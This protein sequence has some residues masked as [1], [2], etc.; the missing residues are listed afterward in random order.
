MSVPPLPI[1]PIDGAEFGALVRTVETAFGE[2]A[3]P[4]DIERERLVFE[5]DRSLAAFDGDRMVG[6]TWVF[7]FGLSVPGG[8]LPAAGVTGVGVLP[9][10]RR[11]G[12]LTR[13]MRRQVD[14]VRD[15]GEPLAALWASEA[16]IY[17]RFGYAPAT[18]GAAHR[19]RKRGATALTRAPAAGGLVRLVDPDFALAAF[20]P[21]YERARSARTG[22]P[23]RRGRW[24]EYQLLADPERHRSGHSDK[25]LITYTEADEVDGYAVYRVKPS[26]DDRGAPTGTVDVVEL[27]AAT[28][29][30]GAALWRHCLG[31]DLTTNI[32][33]PRR[34]LDDP[35]PL[36]LD[37]PRQAQVVV[38][39]ALWLRLV[40]V[41]AALSGRSYASTGRLTLD[42]RDAFCPWNDGRWTLETD[43]SEA[44]C[45]RTRGSADLVLDQTDLA[46][47]YLGGTTATGLAL[48]ARIEERT[49]GA[50]ARLD[51]L[52]R[53]P[54]A[55]WAPEVF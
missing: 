24:W 7:S 37:D 49:P 48:A 3:H 41:P 2:A 45:T 53:V 6:G 43:G 23:S 35:L 31:I 17:G 1:R 15:R 39:D 13:L 34:P 11:Q 46:M 54:L 32:R 26:S 28:P 36:W 16:Q 4:D 22:L 12:L 20:P 47:L 5:P 19:I 9:T 8:E 52:F 33:A 51:A 10:H 25:Q 27:M 18:F 42:V 21:V 30:A 38:A 55:P 44:S 29:A 40:D 50:V 14:D